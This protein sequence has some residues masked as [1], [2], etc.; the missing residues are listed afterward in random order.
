MIRRLYKNEMAEG[1]IR[2]FIVLRIGK[3]IEKAREIYF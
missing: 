1:K 2:F 3:E